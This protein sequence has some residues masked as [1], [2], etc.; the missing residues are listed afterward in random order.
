LKEA[1]DKQLELEEQERLS[2]LATEF[3]LPDNLRDYFGRICDALGAL[4]RS[5]RIWD[6][7]SST[8]TDRYR[9]RTTALQSIQRQ[10]VVV[11][12]GSCALIQSSLTIPRLMNANGG[13]IFIYPAF[14]SLFRL[15]RSLC[16]DRHKGSAYRL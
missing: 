15:A 16:V 4:S 10:P 6:T 5:Q 1:S 3:D 7:I 12:L 9:E 14:H 8:V 13:E 2:R 11:A